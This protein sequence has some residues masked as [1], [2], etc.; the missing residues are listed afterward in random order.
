M[1]KELK[2][3]I[4]SKII[5]SP[6]GIENRLAFL[7]NKIEKG[8]NSGKK[9]YKKLLKEIDNKYPPKSISRGLFDGITAVVFDTAF[10]LYFIGN[11]SALFIELQGL[12]ERFC[13]NA[14]TD[15]LPN[16]LFDQIEVFEI[17]QTLSSFQLSELIAEEILSFLHSKKDEIFIYDKQVY[18]QPS[19]YECGNVS[20]LVNGNSFLLRDYTL[21]AN[22][23]VKQMS[24]E[25]IR[26]KEP[27]EVNSSLTTVF[28]N[29]KNS[30][31]NLTI[32]IYIEYE[33]ER[34][35]THNS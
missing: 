3:L 4:D 32:R 14:L 22:R 8:I 1:N 28:K 26:F 35:T 7:E 10:E 19:P 23:E 29:Y 6:L 25:I 18:I 9:R 2:Q 30:I 31:S 17:G 16:Y 27:L 12:L 13:F 24:K 34:T 5:Q 21:T 20:L 15:L 33:Y 11:N